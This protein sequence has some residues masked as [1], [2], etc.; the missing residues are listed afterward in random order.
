MRTFG[1][2][3]IERERILGR[4]IQPNTKISLKIAE[5]NF[6]G[7][8]PT[9][10]EDCTQS[11]LTV[12]GPDYKGASVPMVPGMKVLV[13]TV[14]DNGVYEFTAQAI[15][16]LRK[17][18]YQVVLEIPDGESI[19]HLQR[20]QFVRLDYHLQIEF[21]LISEGTEAEKKAQPKRQAYTKNISGNGICLILDER[22]TKGTL[23]DIYLPLFPGKPPL[24]VMGEVVRSDEPPEAHRKDF[25]VGIRFVQ[26]RL[27]DQDRIVKLVFDLERQKVRQE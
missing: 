9:R 24:Y 8:Y 27:V 19:R 26:I 12:A 25:D 14:A 15:E 2:R 13:N 20:R 21:Q 7:L 4:V 3:T 22:I 17:P 1:V 10:V 23:M 16:V 18:L 6:A 5:G 11:T